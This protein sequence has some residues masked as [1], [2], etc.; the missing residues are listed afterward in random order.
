VPDRGCER[1]TEHIVPADEIGQELIR[2]GP[3]GVRTD[4]ADV[5]AFAQA[6]GFPDTFRSVPLT[7][8]I[9]WLSLPDVRGE[10]LRRMK[11]DETKIVHWSQS[12]DFLRPLERDRN[13][14]LQLAAHCHP[15]RPDEIL[16][17]SVVR[18]SAGS[19]LVR[20]DTGLRTLVIHPG[21]P[22]A[23][24]AKTAGNEPLLR[25]DF[26]PVDVSQMRRYAAASLDDNP[27]HTDVDVARANG[28]PNVIAHGMM[29]MGNFERA[30]TGWRRDI[31]ITRLNATFLQ[32]LL[33]GRSMV[34]TGRIVKSMQDGNDEL[35]IFRLVVTTDLEDVVC[36]GDATVR[37]SAGG[38]NDL[39]PG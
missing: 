21:R 31:Q 15:S 9:R 38:T 3:I 30:I 1:M 36:I 35:S 34:L 13:Y 20:F 2:L 22:T 29:V 18:D 32:P 25:L 39:T 5:A 14:S 37:V 23:R 6:L 24:R 19:A 4:A 8:P 12:F 10:A 17:R 11:Y 7:F 26:G 33:A 27:I 16:L 28:L